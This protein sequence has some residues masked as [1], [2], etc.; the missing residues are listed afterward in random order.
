MVRKVKG[1]QEDS[2]RVSCHVGTDVLAARGGILPNGRLWPEL[3]TTQTKDVQKWQ[4]DSHAGERCSHW[5]GWCILVLG[6]EEDGDRLGVEGER[7]VRHRGG[8]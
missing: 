2:S 5:A 6:K 1:R 8:V 7:G 4:R 3:S